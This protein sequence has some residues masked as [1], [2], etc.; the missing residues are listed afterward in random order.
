M[1]TWGHGLYSDSYNLATPN[2]ELEAS[3]QRTE[4]M[5]RIHFGEGYSG[6]GCGQGCEVSVLQLWPIL[7]IAPGWVTAKPGS[8]DLLEGM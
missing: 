6:S 1:W 5:Y 4:A 7:D 8:V 2:F 3:G